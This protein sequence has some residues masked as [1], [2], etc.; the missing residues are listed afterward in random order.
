MLAMA[1]AAACGNSRKFSAQELLGFLVGLVVLLDSLGPCEA[2]MPRV[3]HKPRYLWSSLL[4]V[5]LQ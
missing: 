2:A 5:P 3:Q 4:V 1:V